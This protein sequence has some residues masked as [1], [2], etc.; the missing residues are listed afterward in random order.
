MN[1]NMVLRFLFILIIGIPSL[2]LYGQAS[3]ERFSLVEEAS[4]YFDF[5]KAEIRQEHKPILDRMTRSFQN[6][7]GVI[8]NIAAHTDAIGNDENNQSLSQRRADAV[9][10]YFINKGIPAPS[11]R[12]AGFGERIPITENNTE[13]GRQQNRRATIEVLRPQIITPPAYTYTPAPPV[14]PTPA[15]PKQAPTPP[16]E[17]EPTP[18][19]EPPV[20]TTQQP[21]TPAAEP[22]TSNKKPGILSGTVKDLKSDLPIQANVIIRG[23]K[24]LDSTVTDSKGYFESEVPQNSVIGVDVYAPGYFFETKMM[25]VTSKPIEPLVFKLKPADIGAVAEIKNLYFV[26]NQAVLLKK[27]EPELPKVLRFMQ[28]NSTL[29]IEIGGHVNHPHSYKRPV[30]SFQQDLSD[31]RAQMVADYLIKEGISESRI[32]VKG[33]SN[34]EMVFPYALDEPSMARNRRVEI[35]VIK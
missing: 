20:T 3:N 2:H 12:I 34:T 33:Y 9:K 7:T 22:E 29:N 4:I 10:T 32:K 30:G 27:S 15:P 25:K 6:N 21:V 1:A 14:I 13:Q 35:K 19:P 5:A 11:I 26:G 24:F 8:L 18:T 16:K 31:A 28:I 17:P 23:K